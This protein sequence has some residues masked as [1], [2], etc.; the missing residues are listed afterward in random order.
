MFP[1]GLRSPR[2][3]ILFYLLVTSFPRNRP[4]EGP[5]NLAKIEARAMGFLDRGAR[6]SHQA[7]RLNLHPRPDEEDNRYAVEVWVA[8]RDACNYNVDT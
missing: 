5:E 8:A 4:R 6:T 7:L 1:F 3:P 2:R